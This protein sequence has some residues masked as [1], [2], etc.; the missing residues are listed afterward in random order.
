MKSL[1]K[2]VDTLTFPEIVINLFLIEVPYSGSKIVL[3]VNTDDRFCL[4]HVYLSYY[5]LMS[6]PVKNM[7]F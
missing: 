7:E 4:F 6:S 5:S 3:L 2:F 1:I